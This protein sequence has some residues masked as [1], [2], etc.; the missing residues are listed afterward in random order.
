MAWATA[1]DA[2][3]RSFR[4]SGGSGVGLRGGTFTVDFGD[5]GEDF[6][7]DGV[8]FAG[9]VAASGS[10]HWDFD[11]GGIVADLRVDGPGGQDGALHVEGRLFPHTAPLPAS[12]VIGGRSVAVLVPTA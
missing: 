11:S 1:Y 5:A 9:D 3:Q 8:R 4:M 10:A 7:Y 2:I 12:G 6:T